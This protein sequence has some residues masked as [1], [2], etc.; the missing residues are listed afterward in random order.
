M[1]EYL[2]KPQF[3]CREAFFYVALLLLVIGFDALDLRS[4]YH[5]GYTTGR[6]RWVYILM[7][8]R[9]A[10]TSTTNPPPLHLNNARKSSSAIC[11]PMEKGTC[12]RASC[13]HLSSL[14]FPPE[15][16]F[17]PESIRYALRSGFLEAFGSETSPLGLL[18][19][20]ANSGT[21]SPRSKPLHAT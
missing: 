13:H 2:R 15:P 10:Y 5:Y 1:T 3:N 7:T 20:M 8:V 18:F 21:E 4:Q 6:I 16:I 19:S 11:L 17:A 14:L 9:G 12:A